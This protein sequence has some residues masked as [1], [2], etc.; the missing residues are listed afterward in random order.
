MKIV[1]S[2]GNYSMINDWRLTFYDYKNDVFSIIETSCSLLDAS[3]FISREMRDYQVSHV[4]IGFR[5]LNAVTS[6][7]IIA[8]YYKG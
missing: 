3:C 7:H 4:K 8:M 6:Y 2:D 5:F 1:Y